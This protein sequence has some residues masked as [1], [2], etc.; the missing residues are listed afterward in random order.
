M[1]CAIK[2]LIKTYFNIEANNF[3]MLLNKK[4]VVK[5]LTLQMVKNQKKK[6][7][8]VNS[9]IQKNDDK[10]LSTWTCE[11][12]RQFLKSHDA[13]WQ[14]NQA[15][16]RVR[17]LL[18]KKIMHHGLENLISLSKTKLRS[19]WNELKLPSGAEIVKDDLTVSMSNAMVGDEN[20]AVE[21]MLR[22][23]EEEEKNENAI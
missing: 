3:T 7:R 20:Y 23:I 17:C 21:S 13:V 6:G 1:K 11:H 16:L 4:E 18:L 5:K 2:P 12:C 19:M 10:D 8:R 22:L 9:L 14:G 15:E